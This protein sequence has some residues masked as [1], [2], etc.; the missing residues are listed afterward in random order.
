MSDDMAFSLVAIVVIVFLLFLGASITRVVYKTEI[1]EY[2][3]AKQRCEKSLPRD[4]FC[5]VIITAVP[6]PKVE[7]E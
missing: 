7:N 3:I 2:L 1:D 5:K 4:Q 6:V